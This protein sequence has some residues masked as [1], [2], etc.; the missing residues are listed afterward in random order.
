[1]QQLGKQIRTGHGIVNSVTT[2]KPLEL[3]HMALIGPIQTISLGG[4]KYILVVVDNYSRFTWVVFLKDKGETFIHF[5]S[6][7]N[8]IQNKKGK[9]VKSLSR[10]RGDHGIEFDNS[11]FIEYYDELGIRH[12]FS[13]P[14]TP[15]Q[16]GVVERKNK[17]L[18]EMPRVRLSSKTFPKYFWAEAKNTSCYVVNRVYI[19]PSN[20]QISNLNYE[21]HFKCSYMCIVL[22]NAHAQEKLN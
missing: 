1:M 16:N 14:I 10:M 7:V 5:K 2:T 6:V 4:K 15:Q 20:F 19:R 17:V 8:K 3:I 13:S 9:I 18:I 21:L 12:E 11:S 22:S